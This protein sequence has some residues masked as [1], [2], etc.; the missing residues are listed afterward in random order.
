MAAFTTIATGGNMQD[1]TFLREIEQ[2]FYERFQAAD[3]AA[4][5]PA[6]AT[7]TGSTAA[8]DNIQQ[9]SLW[10]ARQN[11]VGTLITNAAHSF[12]Q[13]GSYGSPPAALPAVN[14][15]ASLSLYSAASDLWAKVTGNSGGPRRCTTTPGSYTYGVCQAGDI[16]GPWLIEDLQLAMAHLKYFQVHDDDVELDVANGYYRAGYSSDWQSGS[17]TGTGIYSATNF[18][19][20]ETDHDNNG[21]EAWVN[22]GPSLPTHV[23]SARAQKWADDPAGTWIY[24]ARSY[25]WISNY[26]ITLP[27]SGYNHKLHLGGEWGG[28]SVADD[29][30]YGLFSR[31]TGDYVSA[32]NIGVVVSDSSWQS[33]TSRYLD[34]RTMKRRTFD[35]NCPDPVDSADHVDVDCYVNTPFCLVEW[36]FT[37]DSV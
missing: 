29:D 11:A 12:V 8:G 10:A 35:S 17:F 25:V 9:A 16:L 20:A 24:Y 18:Q 34:L 22:P 14:N 7:S 15:Q 1:K 4:S 27:T 19:Y 36:Q 37:K 6:W 26:T 28:W 30:Y 2:A 32:G 23:M 5:C 13:A 3:A 31:D 21:L 33:G